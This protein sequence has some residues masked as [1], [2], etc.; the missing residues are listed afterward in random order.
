MYAND[1]VQIFQTINQETRR[2]PALNKLQLPYC[3]YLYRLS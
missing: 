1:A 2:P 3:L